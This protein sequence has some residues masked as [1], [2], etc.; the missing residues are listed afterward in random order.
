MAMTVVLTSTAQAEALRLP[1]AI[2]TRVYEVLA[3]LADFPNISGYKAL[4]HG[5]KGHYRI[6]TGDYRVIFYVAAPNVIVVRIANRRD[7]YEED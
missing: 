7:V 2:K 4:K 1:A 5:W 3:R 6:R